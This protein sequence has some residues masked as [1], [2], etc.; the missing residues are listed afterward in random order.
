MLLPVALR[1]GNLLSSLQPAG[2]ALI[3][4]MTCL[5][6]KP[7]ALDHSQG[8]GVAAATFFSPSLSYS[9]FKCYLFFKHSLALIHFSNV[10]YEP[11][12]RSRHR[13]LQQ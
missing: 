1:T 12:N 13:G 4:Q 5:E 10:H 6:M 3:S 8:P 2:P 11:G 9:F 7:S